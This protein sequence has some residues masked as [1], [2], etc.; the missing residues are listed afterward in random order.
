MAELSKGGRWKPGDPLLPHVK[1]PFGTLEDLAED[2]VTASVK[3]A[4]P[5]GSTVTEAQIGAAATAQLK[6]LKVLVRML[7]G[8]G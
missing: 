8:G 7:R 5:T 6:H 3:A 4:Q 2:R 1:G